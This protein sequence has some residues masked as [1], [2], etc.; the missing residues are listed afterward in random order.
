MQS[1]TLGATGPPNEPAIPFMPALPWFQIG[2]LAGQAALAAI[3]L[4]GLFRLRR[5]AGLSPLYI[6]LGA[7]QQ[8]QV[9]LAISVYVE[10]TPMLIINP[11][12]AVLFPAS[13]FTILLVYLRHDASEARRLV[14]GIVLANLSLAM[15]SWLASLHLGGPATHSLIELPREFFVQNLR[16]L[17]AGTVTLFL[18][19]LLMIVVYEALG[20]WLRRWLFLHIFATLAATLAFDAVIF[21]S[22]A[23]AGAPEYLPLLRSGLIGKVLMA[24]PYSVVLAVF[25]RFQEPWGE[26]GEI[27]PR[28]VRRLDLFHPLSFRQRYLTAREEAVRDALTGLHNRR[29]FDETLPMSLARAERSGEP[30]SVLLMDVDRFKE[31]NDRLGHLAGDAVLRHVAGVLQR[32]ARAQDLVCRYGGDEIVVVMPGGGPDDAA[33]LGRRIHEALAAAPPPVLESAARRPTLSMGSASYPQDAEEADELL[34]LADR[35]LY[36]SRIR[37]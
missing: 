13:L 10:I 4:I 25:L 24:L 1:V 12:S 30:L 31:I 16:V 17:I 9:T 2:L 35:R 8:L 19:V 23:F 21:A 22:G 27:I 29:F 34:R 3:V 7:L 37:G 11:G 14:Y 6:T 36:A 32:T 5:V 26:T 28:Q 15:L 20:R 33:A 18:D